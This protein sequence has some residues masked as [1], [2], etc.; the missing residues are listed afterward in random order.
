MELNFI[1][2]PPGARLGTPESLLLLTALAVLVALYWLRQRRATAS[3]RYSAAYAA[4][5]VKPSAWVR[6]RHLPALL[7][8]LAVVALIVALARPQTVRYERLEEVLSYGADIMLV[9]DTSGSMEALDYQ[10]RNRLHVARETV[11]SFVE[12]RRGDRIGLVAFSGLAATVCPLTT[13]M[14]YLQDK[15]SELDFGLLEDGTAIGTAIS[16]ALN[17]LAGSAARSKVIILLT[18]GVNNRGEVSPLDAAA[19]A[20]DMEVKVYTVGVGSEGPVPFPAKPPYYG[21]TLEVGLDE[22]LLER[23]AAETGG[24]YRGATDPRSL[25][26]IYE[27]IDRLEKTEVR[28]RT[29]SYPVETEYFHWFLYPALVLLALERLLRWTRLGVLP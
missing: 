20:R 11:R 19:I 18:D 10:P 2:F 12:G 26:R 14:G 6:L 29:Y 8:W 28:A 4:R 16:T 17:R 9:M 1:G 7:R 24:V 15:V 21:R 13:N 5:R 27:E 25:A 23:I 22:E 3:L